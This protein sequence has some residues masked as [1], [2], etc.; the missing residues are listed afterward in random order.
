MMVALGHA[1]R[2][3]PFL[4]SCLGLEKFWEETFNSR[5]SRKQIQVAPP[6]IG[7]GKDFLG[8]KWKKLLI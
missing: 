6:T 3:A 2:A 1:T 5:N 7:L 4:R 8:E